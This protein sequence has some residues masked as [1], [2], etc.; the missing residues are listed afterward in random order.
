MVTEKFSTSRSLLGLT[1]LKKLQKKFRRKFLRKKKTFY[2]SFIEMGPGDSKI[3]TQSLSNS[4][5]NSTLLLTHPTTT[6][7]N[8]KANNFL[9]D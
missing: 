6:N 9:S 3:Q 4:S 5:I 7:K 8:L 2:T 1:T